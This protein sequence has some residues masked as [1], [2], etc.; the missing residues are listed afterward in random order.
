MCARWDDGCAVYKFGGNVTV[1]VEMSFSL[2]LSVRFLGIVA[3]TLGALFTARNEWD[4][5]LRESG[6]L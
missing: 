4:R 6:E 3:C 1:E 5:R 2:R